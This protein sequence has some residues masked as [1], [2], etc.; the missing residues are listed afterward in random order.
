MEVRGIRVRMGKRTTLDVPR[1][2]VLPGE[3]LGVIGPNG[4]GKSTLLRVLGLLQRPS[5]GEVYFGGQQINLRGDLVPYRRRIA[6]VFQE[7]LLLNTSVRDNAA[8]GLKLR[9][10][11]GREAYKRVAPWLERFG[12][13]GL[14]DRKARTLSGGEAQRVSLVRALALDPEVLLLDEPFSALDAP[15]RIS[16]IEDLRPIL[17]ERKLTTVFVTHD[18]GEALALSDRLAVLID[19]QLR[20]VGDPNEVFNAP[21]ATDV[22]AFVGAENIIPGRVTEQR[23][24]LVTVAVGG[25]HVE[26]VADWPVGQD[27]HVLLRPEDITLSLWEDRPRATSARNKV[28]GVV[29]RAIPLG[30]LT[31]VFVYCGGFTLIVLITQQSYLELG[32]RPDV[33]VCASFKATAVHVI[34]RD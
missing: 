19:G 7:A 10:I 23:G 6:V 22:A 31:R 4:S 20:Q 29:T 25:D 28:R 18:R 1:L 3:T 16:L 33:E 2:E 5:E 26:A 12:I 24:G 9:G 30:A 8:L 13:G 14:A 34:K 21:A 27:V 32:L 15:T 11:T 17:A